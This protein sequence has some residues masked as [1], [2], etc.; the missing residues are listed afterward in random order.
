M[1]LYLLS[2]LVTAP[3]TQLR[4]VALRKGSRQ[5]KLLCFSRTLEIRHN[6]LVVYII[7]YDKIDRRS[8]PISF[9]CYA[10]KTLIVV[11]EH[12]VCILKA[13]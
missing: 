9:I 11:C 6:F 1:K 3:F 10:D 8:A 7:V 2:S 13:D 5:T 4:L 12:F